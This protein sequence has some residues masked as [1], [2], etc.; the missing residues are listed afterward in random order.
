MTQLADDLPRAT[1][2]CAGALEMNSSP[3]VQRASS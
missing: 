1:L 2:A 3:P